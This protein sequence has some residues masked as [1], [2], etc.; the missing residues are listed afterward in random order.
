[1][2]EALAGR[3]HLPPLSDRASST[4]VSIR[5]LSA[6]FGN[7]VAL[8]NVTAEVRTGDLI[9]ILGPNGAGKSTLL[10]ALSGL[11]A[12]TVTGEIVIDGTDVSRAGPV[13]RAKAGIG[14]SF[15]DPPLVESMTVLENVLSGGWL[16]HR[17]NVGEQIFRPRKSGRDEAR[18]T[19]HA[20]A[21]LDFVG[22][23]R[24]AD[25]P[26]SQ[27]P[28]GPRKLTDVA[29]ALMGGPGLVLFDEPSSGLDQAE[30]AIVIDI[31]ND[32]KASGSVAVLVVEHHMD[33]VRAAATRVIGLQA[34][35]VIADGTATQVL[36]SA[37]F[38][39]ALV[40]AKV[41][42]ENGGDPR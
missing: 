13:A 19:A 24:L 20:R 23:S 30:T 33:V 25:V 22:L 32:L 37:E 16:Q 15:Q 5:G 28:Y 38:R 1:M 36:D 35:E 3:G 31:L 39:A 14:R 8:H 7:V 34:G 21:L 42:R 10:N 2:V 9:A 41:G 17:Y 12:G 6:R 27:I 26:A 40:N 18:L 11:Q 29:R 4:T